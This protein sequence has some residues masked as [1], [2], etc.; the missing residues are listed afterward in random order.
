M[1]KF[2]TPLRGLLL[3]ALCAC[4]RETAAPRSIRAHTRIISGVAHANPT[5]KA[6]RYCSYCHGAGLS[7]GTHFEPSCYQCHGKNWTQDAERAGETAAPA[8]HS[9]LKGSRFYHKQTLLTPDGDCTA[10][11]GATLEGTA[12][13]PSCEL[14]HTKL[15]VRE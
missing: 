8:D 1:D 14:C 11:H 4:S 15:W 2:I 9:V 3:V 7:G 13:Y 5:D 6:E 12:S 10:C